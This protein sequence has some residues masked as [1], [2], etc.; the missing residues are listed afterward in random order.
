MISSFTVKNVKSLRDVTIEPGHFNVFIGANG[1]G[2]SN[3]LEALAL[4]AGAM[5]GRT[6]PEDL[7][8]RGYRV[9]RP[10]STRSSFRGEEP[11]EA[12]TLGAVHAEVSPWGRESQFEL[13]PE[14]TDLISASWVDA[15]TSPLDPQEMIAQIERIVAHHP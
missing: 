12:I 8:N 9:A 2:K 4:L 10:D 5:T 7:F 14:P 15:S 6:T 13:L 1:C 3:V 11:V